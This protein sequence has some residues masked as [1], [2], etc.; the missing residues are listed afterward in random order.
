MQIH[1]SH[2]DG[3]PLVIFDSIKHLPSIGRS[4]VL[5][6]VFDTACIYRWT[7]THGYITNI[8]NCKQNS[9]KR[10]RFK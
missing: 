8:N 3:T 7:P 5:Y 9:R 6:Y 4:D 10:K 1:I 2:I